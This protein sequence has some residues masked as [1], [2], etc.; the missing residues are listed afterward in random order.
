MITDWLEKASCKGKHQDFWFPPL[1]S[2]NPNDYYS[3]AKRVCSTCPV[4]QECLSYSDEETWGCWAGLIPKERFTKASLSH[5]SFERSRLG[6]PCNLCTT[7]K[8]PRPVDLDKVPSQW[9]SF[10]ISQ[11]MYLL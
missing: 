10:D 3:I 11:L 6:C 7:A 5:G 9:D 2:K 4:W 8:P 1:E